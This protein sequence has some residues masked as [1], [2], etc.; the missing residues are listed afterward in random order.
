VQRTLAD[1]A[2]GDENTELAKGF[3]DKVNIAASLIWQMT[4]DPKEPDQ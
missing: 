3:L 2:N 4:E 1:K